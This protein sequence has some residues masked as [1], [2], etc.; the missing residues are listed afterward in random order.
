MQSPVHTFTERAYS[1][2][3]Y[4]APA[5]HKTYTHF[6]GLQPSQTEDDEDALQC[7]RKK[8]AST[9]TRRMA[10]DWWMTGRGS[11]TDAPLWMKNAPHKA[12][13]SEGPHTMHHD[14]DDG[15]AD[16]GRRQSDVRCNTNLQPFIEASIHI[17]E[18]SGVHV[19]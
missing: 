7:S 15:D 19:H 17:Y 14:D 5:M 13:S 8:E 3:Y 18:L 2:S 10:Y 12:S 6:G 9:Q 11:V 16:D 1:C 4:T